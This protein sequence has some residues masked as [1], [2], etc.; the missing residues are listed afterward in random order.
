MLGA[1]GLF[2]KIGSMVAAFLAIIAIGGVIL[3]G[4]RFIATSDRHRHY[5]GVSVC[6]NFVWHYI[7]I[8]DIELA[9]VGAVDANLEIADRISVLAGIRLHPLHRSKYRPRH[10]RSAGLVQRC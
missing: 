8:R 10:C 4:L 6:I 9:Q 3:G 5:D 2:A 7:A 1:P